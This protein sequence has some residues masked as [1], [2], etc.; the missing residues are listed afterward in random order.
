MVSELKKEAIESFRRGELKKAY[1]FFRRILSENPEDKEAIYYSAV[2]FHRLE[3]WR[4]AKRF[5]LQY[6]RLFGSDP[7]MEEILGDVLSFEGDFKTAVKWYKKSLKHSHEGSDRVRN[8]LKEAQKKLE[9]S[10]DKKKIAVVVAEGADAFTDDLIERLSEKYWVRKFSVPKK[11]YYFFFSALAVLYGRNMLKPL[12]VRFLFS[13]FPNTLKRALRW[14]DV[15]WI[16]WASPVAVVASLLKRKKKTFVRL[17]RYEA[18]RTY[19]FLKENSSLINWQNLDGVIF[20]SESVKK[21]VE[22]RGTKLPEKTVVIHNGLNLEK[23]SFEE[24]S[25]GFDIGWVAGIIPRKNLHLALEI[26][27]RLVQ[28]DTR[29]TLHVAGEFKDELYEIY[30]KHLVKEMKL[31]NNVIFYG[32]VDDIDAW[33]KDKNYILS[34]SFHEG[35][36]YNIM[37]AM[38]KGIKPVIHNFPGAREFY[39]DEFLFNSVDEAVQKIVEE[40]YDSKRYRDYVIKKGWTI[41]HQVKAFEEFI[42]SL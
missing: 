25:K 6:L 33:W 30:I 20:V 4:T 41:E 24:K 3:R 38:A 1:G 2:I 17:H 19:S 16:E 31:E 29:Y 14:A 10:L 39:D 26:M 42:E 7:S 15:V 32:W 34:T 28:I 35:H 40:D 5:A 18:F 22:E 11:E 9:E 12:V 8:K 37:E 21:I 23:V 36:P 27:G 13:I